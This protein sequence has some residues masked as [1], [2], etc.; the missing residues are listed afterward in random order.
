MSGTQ[1]C[2]L[3]EELGNLGKL[4]HLDLQRTHSLKA[5]PSKAISGLQQLRVLNLYYSCSQWEAQNCYPDPDDEN[6]VLGLVDLEC[7]RQLAKLGISVTKL[8]TLERLSGLRTLL[9]CI[10]SLY[11]K[12]CEGLSHL[13]IPSSTSSTLRRLSIYNCF[14]LEYLEIGVGISGVNSQLRILEVLALHELP[15]LTTV[16]RNPSVARQCLHNLRYVNIWYCHSL[17]NI[18]WARSL[19]RLEVIYLFY[20]REMEEV[21]AGNVERSGEAAFPSL[22]TLSIRELPKLRTICQWALPFPS[23]ERLAVVD[24]PMLKRLPIKADK[25]VSNFPTLYGSKVWW[26]ELEW[27]EATTKSAFVPHF[28]A[29]A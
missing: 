13:R 21:V 3:P 25:N 17:K 15:N 24:C 9:Q 4:R 18:S 19:P 1:L 7:M 14:D 22:R 28:M 29:T 8:A 16:W 20:C 10:Q 26:D 6:R 23:L 11:I 12:D 5:I 27:D 2:I